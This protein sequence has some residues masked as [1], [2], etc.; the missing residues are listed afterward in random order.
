MIGRLRCDR[1]PSLR[2]LV[3][4][5]G[6]RIVPANEIQQRK[7]TTMKSI[8]IIALL[9][10]MSVSTVGAQTAY[11]ETFSPDPEY[12]LT[13]T[14]SSGEFAGVDNDGYYKLQ[15]DETTA[16]VYKYAYS[17]DLGNYEDTSFHFRCDVM[18]AENHRGFPQLLHLANFDESY[19][20]SV[21]FLFDWNNIAYLRDSHGHNYALG[22]Y[23]LGR[24]YIYEFAYN[25]DTG[26]L[27]VV[28]TDPDT[29]EDLAEHRGVPFDP[30]SFN[31]IYLG[32]HT[33]NGDGQGGGTIY[34][35]NLLLEPIWVVHTE[36]TTWGEVKALYR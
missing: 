19:G 35:D 24:W 18:V 30:P 4:S 1:L 16:G 5:L 26:L 34:F 29:G 7:G 10:L 27:D 28:K 13:W 23:D 8:L 12:Q 9:A 22:S 14:L 32:E 11:E 31:R 21:S 3:V 15:V 6:G 33:I 36:E 25:V 2:I 17:E 20:K